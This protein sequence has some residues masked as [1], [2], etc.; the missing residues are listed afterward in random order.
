M[1]DHLTS[2]SETKCR[3]TRGSPAA[4]LAPTLERALEPETHE[5]RAGFTKVFRWQVPAEQTSQP[6]TVEVIG[7]F[8]GWRKVPLSYDAPSRSWQ[9]ILNNIEG[10][11][12][13][14]YVILVD[15]K[16]S[17][18]QNC[19]GLVVPQTPEEKQWGIATPRGARVMLLFA[20]TK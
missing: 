20:Q 4:R 7:S 3:P 2:F 12:T 17:F 15:G 5:P 13:H 14:Q 8:T 18:D 1:I 16:P 9:V 11:H 19:D 10:N 6:T